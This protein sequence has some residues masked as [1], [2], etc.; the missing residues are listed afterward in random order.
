FFQLGTEEGTLY[1][2]GTLAAF[3]AQVVPA[4]ER[5][6][7]RSLDA[8]PPERITRPPPRRDAEGRDRTEVVPMDT[9]VGEA[10]RVAQA[11]RSALT[12]G[13]LPTFGPRERKSV[14]VVE[15]ALEGLPALR[16]QVGE[17]RARAA[18][19]DFLRVAE[20]VAYKHHAH[21]ERL[22]ERGF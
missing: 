18:L 15:G 3:I 5:G 19:L 21:C 17:P 11:T 10:E 6:K 13:S 22:D 1:E 2:S 4:E 14:L 20:H 12:D 7:I 8:P 9:P 16:R